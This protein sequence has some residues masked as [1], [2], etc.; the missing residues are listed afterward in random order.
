[1]L[2]YYVLTAMCATM[3]SLVMFTATVAPLV[4]WESLTPEG[5]LW[6]P[7]PSKQGP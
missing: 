3:C 4:V 5:F 2:W 1:M 7:L 6:L